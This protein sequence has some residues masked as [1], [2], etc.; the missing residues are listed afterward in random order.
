MSSRPF[1][2]WWADRITVGWLVER[3]WPEPEI[4]LGPTHC[5]VIRHDRF[6]W[7]MRDPYMMK[8]ASDDPRQQWGQMRQAYRFPTEQAAQQCLMWQ[9]ITG[10][11]EKVD[12]P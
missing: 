3:I 4:H 7:Y 12:L 1:R 6:L 5:Y 10:V 9:E 2:D 11:I 8:A